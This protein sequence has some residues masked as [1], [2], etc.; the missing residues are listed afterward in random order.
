[1]NEMSA[2]KLKNVVSTDSGN[3]RDETQLNVEMNIF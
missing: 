3:P 2:A 1:M